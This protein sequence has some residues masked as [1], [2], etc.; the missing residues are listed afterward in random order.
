MLTNHPKTIP[1]SGLSWQLK[2]L[3]I[4]PTPPAQSTTLQPLKEFSISFV[5]VINI[6]PMVPISEASVPF[7]MEYY[8]KFT[9]YFESKEF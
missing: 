6:S 2:N 5:K 3:S 8:N 1:L 9:T 4:E 7:G